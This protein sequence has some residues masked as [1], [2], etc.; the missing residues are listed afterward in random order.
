MVSD[1]GGYAWSY[2]GTVA[3][4]SQ[5]PDEPEGPCES[6]SSSLDDGK[7]FC[8]YRV[9]SRR[10]NLY[11]SSLSLDGGTTWSTPARISGAW[12][13]ESKLTQLDNGAILLSG[14][15]PGLFLWVCDH[16][17][18][19]TWVPI[20]LTQHHN[21]STMDSRY[22][23]SD[24]TCN[25]EKSSDPAQTTAYTGLARAGSDSAV[26][27]YDRLANGWEGAPGP[28][29]S[30]DTLFSVTITAAFNH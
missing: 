29:G 16:A 8:V 4:W 11:C 24:K 21:D 2:Q 28:W 3:S 18:A 7:L 14:G 6:N 1:D 26:L 19:G 13:V 5:I 23:F 9:G 25:A 12:S 22:A 10:T 15:R 30:T 27:C 20:N 17:M